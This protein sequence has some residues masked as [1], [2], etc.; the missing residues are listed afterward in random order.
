[1][2]LTCQEPGYREALSTSKVPSVW[3]PVLHCSVPDR[4]IEASK[5]RL[6][7]GSL[8]TWVKFSLFSKGIVV[9]APH[10]LLSSYY[11]PTQC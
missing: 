4:H 8:I 10:F 1:M 2:S 6:S 11:V 9:M 3:G 7:P 5:S